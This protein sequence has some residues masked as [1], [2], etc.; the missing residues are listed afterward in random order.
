MSE[1]T[2]PECGGQREEGADSGGPCPSC[3][4]VP[5]E[6][7][8]R[9]LAPGPAATEAQR[10]WSA[11]TLGF[12]AR[13]ASAAAFAVGLGL[14]LVG[15]GNGV[16]RLVRLGDLGGPAGVV[17]LLFH[18]AVA[19]TQVVF[20]AALLPV[21]L[22][23]AS[24]DERVSL[25]SPALLFAILWAVVGLFALVVGTTSGANA[26][27]AGIVLLL[28]GGFG[29]LAARTYDVRRSERGL[30]AGVM[31]LVAG[32]LLIGG[33]AAVPGE[34][35]WLGG[36]VVLRYGGPVQVTGYLVAIL[37]A[38]V[39]PFVRGR[40]RG[41]A[42]AALIGALGGVVW[43]LGELVFAADWLAGGPW[44]PFGFLDA[45]AAAGYGFVFAGGLATI[46]G[47]LAGLGA[48]IAAA[49]HASV[50]L[51]AAAGSRR[52]EQVRCAACSADVDP[53]ASFCPD[54]GAE[55]AAAA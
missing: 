31:G 7:S 49:G 42:G 16:V 46:V 24:P 19:S 2:C 38:S 33:V 47:G 36:E 41:T 39:Y 15:V 8:E 12:A 52:G 34:L 43:G 1:T 48:A 17:E 4:F 11:S 21:G 3:G 44:G 40:R 54:C 50:P 9:G 35:P 30:V 37:A 29:S 14:V 23:A 51:A 20:G 53:G 26:A 6:V 25:E 22:Q 10:D 32:G 5:A 18:L 27:G 55:L 45:G 28:A 13:G